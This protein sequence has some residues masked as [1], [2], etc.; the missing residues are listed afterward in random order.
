MS[1]EPWMTQVSMA[2]DADGTIAL[3]ASSLTSL[4]VTFVGRDGSL[5]GTMDVLP[6]DWDHS[7]SGVL[8]FPSGNFAFITS[9]RNSAAPHYGVDRLTLRT[10]GV[11]SL[12]PLPSAPHVRVSGEGPQIDVHWT[13]AAGTV[14]GYRLEH[15]TDDGVWIES[16]RWFGPDE[17]TASITRPAYG[18]TFAVRVRAVNDAGTGEYSNVAQLPRKRR[19]LR[20]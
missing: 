3:L 4:V 16:E 5:R 7:M 9:T 11:G 13:P 14:N 18:T 20:G 10:V 12:P 17:L 1:M 6:K 8:P 15:R 2:V 19:A